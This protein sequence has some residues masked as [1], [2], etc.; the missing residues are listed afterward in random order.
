MTGRPSG[1]T[2][3]V[4][5]AICVELASGVSLRA[6]CRRDDMPCVDTVLKWVK[7][8]P[9]FAEQYASAREAQADTIFDEILDIADDPKIT[10]SEAVQVAKMRI[11]ARKWMA[12]KMR[13]KKYGERLDLAHTGADGG[14]VQVAYANVA[15]L[16][17]TLRDAA[18]GRVDAKA[19]EPPAKALQSPDRDGSDLL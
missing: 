5:D 14:P 9:S 15:E 7:K 1:F 12:G 2:Q 4:A 6:I 17:R 11:D 10:D 8:F 3:A 18:A 13:P 16:A 19:I